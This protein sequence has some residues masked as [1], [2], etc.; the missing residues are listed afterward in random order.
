MKKTNSLFR[1]M[2]WLTLFAV[3][4][5]TQTFA[6]V[7]V[8][9]RLNTS[10]C[11][12]TLQTTH[13]VQVRG[14]SKL[15]TTPAITWDT[16][17]GIKLTNIGGDYWEGTIQA[18]TGDSISYK[19]WTGF[20]ISAG[21]FH[22]TGW[23]G[24]QDPGV[25]FAGTNRALI[26]GAKDTVLALQYFNGGDTKLAQYWRPFP[27]KT[28]SIA[29]YFRVNM[30][31]ADFV[32]ATGIVD[33]RGGLPLGPNSWSPAIKVLSRDANSVNGGSFWSGVAYVAK[34]SITVGTT[35]Q[36]YKYVIQPDKWESIS[37]RSFIFSSKNDTTI[38]WKYYNN[39]APAGPKVIANLLFSLKLQA[40]EKAGLF[41]R[42]LGDKVAVTGA[43]GWPPGTFV[44]KDEPTMLKM[45]YDA[46]LREWDLTESFTKYPKEVITY[47]Y[48]ISWDTTRVVSTNANYIPGLALSNGWEE[49]GVTGGADRQYVYTDQT[50]QVIVGDFGSQT[51]FFNSLHWKGGIT[52]PI[53]V[54]FK[55]NM[56][57]ATS[58]VTNPSTLFRP[59]I[60]TVYIQFDGSLAAVTQGKTMWGTDNRIRLTDP[61]GDGKYTATWDMKAP[62]L[63][64]FCYRL[65]YTSPSGEIE[66]GSG[67]AVLGRRYYQYVHPVDV[68][69]DSAKWPST[70]SLP[71]MPWMLDKLTIE[72]PPDLDKVT[73]G[74]NG[75]S[76]VLNS[77]QLQQNYPNPFN[78]STI[79]TYSIPV[80]SRVKIEIFNILGQRV[81]SLFNQDQIAGTHS[82][83]WNSRDDR[84]QRVSSGVYLLKM[85][86]GTFSQVK[87]ML[88][89]K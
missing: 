85:Q 45:T 28:D 2:L 12:D 5:A 88:L 19:F 81:A 77:Y 15:G 3:V 67:S 29:V 32:P 74:V 20:T 40:L 7:S 89:T 49:P 68:Y 22:W 10:T 13:V 57:P 9:F 25:A 66:N 62:T 37:N 84:G 14:A 82:I 35:K 48:Y 43:K 54:T 21:T 42:N 18:V 80:N 24:D 41:N 1:P 72:D 30:G 53:K 4:V 58:A 36:E 31:G 60:D 56:A 63:Y 26:V 73:V 61:D 51:Q 46:D 79:V 8:K 6:T 64:Q 83:A 16:A 71:E 27:S 76:H 47:K 52:T 33:V 69:A 55:I 50:S 34:D 70:F 38:Q 11:L 78:P 39:F 59:G 75:S 87:K 17:T 65:V 23:D 86:A 44:F